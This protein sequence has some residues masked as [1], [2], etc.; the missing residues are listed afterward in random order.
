MKL[1]LDGRMIFPGYKNNDGTIDLEV[2]KT[3][4]VIFPSGASVRRI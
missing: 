4:W 2:G 3:Q 1:A